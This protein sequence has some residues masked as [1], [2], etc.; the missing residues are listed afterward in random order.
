L[1]SLR[2]VAFNQPKDGQASGAKQRSVILPAALIKWYQRKVE[3]PDENFRWRIFRIT[4]PLPN[5]FRGA[6][7][8]VQVNDEELV[9]IFP[10]VARNAVRSWSALRGKQNSSNGL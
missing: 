10:F 6:W 9:L 4:R 8:T 2:S 1:R 5:C 7:G 3:L